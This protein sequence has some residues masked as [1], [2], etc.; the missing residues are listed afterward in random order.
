[1]GCTHSTKHTITVTDD[2][3]F[4]EWFRW[5]P[6]P[7]V[8]EVHHHLGEMLESGTIQPSQSAWCNV[9]VLVR[10]RMEAYTSV[11]TL[12]FECPYRKGLLPP[13]TNSRGIAKSGRCWTF[14]VPG[15]QVGVLANKNGGG[16]KTVY[17]LH[18]RQ[19]GDLGFFKCDHML[20]RLCNAPATFQQLM[21]NCL[22]ELNLIYLDDVIVFLQTAKEHLHQLCVVFD[23]F[24]EYN[25]KLNPSKCSLF[26]EEINYLAQWVSKEGV[27][28]SNLNLKV[29]TECALPQTYTEVHAFLCIMGHYWQF[30][31][32]F[33]HITQLLNEHLTGEGPS[34]QLEWVSLLENPLEA[35]AAL[36]QACMSTLI[37]AFTNYTKEFLLETNASKEGLGAVLYQKQAD[38]QYHLVAYGS[39]ALMAHEKNYHSTKLEFLVLKWAVK[40]HFKEYLPYQPFL[41][42]TNNNTLTYIMTTPNLNATGHWWVGALARFNFQ[43]EYQKGCDNTMADVL[44]W[45]HYPF[46]PGHGE[47]GTRWSDPRGHPKGWMS[48]PCSSWGRPM[49][50]KRGTCCCRVGVGPNACDWL[51]RSPERRP[52][53]EH[54]LRL[55]GTPKEDWPEDTL[56]RACLQWGRPTDSEESS[57]LHNTSEGPIPMLHA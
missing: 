40:E 14:F 55:V 45:D 57:K 31:K 53:A 7:L 10:K 54:G 38:G 36:K 32:G 28:P 56:R 16:I 17:C 1:M 21:Q 2:T 41:V 11:L 30:I 5:I 46:Q 26:K 44:S 29:I 48:S 8:E 34:R 20:L 6:P 33:T 25:L 27:Q 39:R 43:L 35:F 19:F 37:L 47:T 23:Q 50:G 49:H 42:K 18:S 12:L 24:R 9:V 51:G 13:A 52:S 3:P 22:S 4:I 15:P